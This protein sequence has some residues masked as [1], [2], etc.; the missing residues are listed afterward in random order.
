MTILGKDALKVLFENG[1]VPDEGDYSDLID[2]LVALKVANGIELVE[3]TVPSTPPTGSIILYAVTTGFLSFKN[4]LGVAVPMCINQIHPNIFGSLKS[5][6]TTSYPTGL[7]Q[8]VINFRNSYTDMIDMNCH[9]P[10]GWGGILSYGYLHWSPSSTDTGNVRWCIQI[11][12][13]S[14]GV[15]LSGTPE[16]EIYFTSAGPGIVNRVVKGWNGSSSPFYM[17]N[18]VEG[19]VMAIRILR[20]G[21]HT[22]DTFTGTAQLSSFKLQGVL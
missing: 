22:D 14:D 7:N 9:L 19:D 8:A 1:K 13:V 6:A 4:D 20:D 21:T 11:R 2:T 5:G 17:T 3:G 16:C 12:R 10:R 15:T 18:F